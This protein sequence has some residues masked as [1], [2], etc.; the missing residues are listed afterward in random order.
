MIEAKFQIWPYSNSRKFAGGLNHFW[1]YLFVHIYKEFNYKVGFL[2]KEAITLQEGAL[3][4][5]EFRENALFSEIAIF[6]FG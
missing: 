4:K 5:Q 2:S 1:R 3:V 6:V